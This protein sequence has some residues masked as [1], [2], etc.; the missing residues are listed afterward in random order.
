MA[1]SEIVKVTIDGVELALKVTGA[2]ATRIAAVLAACV[3]FGANQVFGNT[4]G[5]ENIKKL[6]KKGPITGFSIRYKDL[7]KFVR[8][9]ERYGVKYSA[10]T[11][12]D[13]MDGVDVPDPN[14]IVDIFFATD[15]AAQIERL[16]N[17]LDIGGID[18]VTIEAEDEVENP[19]LEN[20]G[21]EKTP[22]ETVAGLFG[23]KPEVANAPE[24]L[25]TGER[26]LQSELSSE[27]TVSEKS[28]SKENNASSRVETKITGEENYISFTEK[29]YPGNSLVQGKDYVFG[30]GTYDKDTGEI[31]KDINGQDL[32]ATLIFTPSQDVYE[33]GI[34][35][36]YKLDYELAGKSIGMLETVLYDG[37]I[38]EQLSD[39]NNAI[40]LPARGETVEVNQMEHEQDYK[41]V[42]NSG[43]GNEGVWEKAPEDAIAELFSSGPGANEGIETLITGGSESVN[44]VVPEQLK[45][46]IR[47]TLGLSRNL[48]QAQNNTVDKW[49]N[50]YGMPE[51]IIKEA[52]N[53]AASAEVERPFAYAN[54][55]IETWHNDGV[56]SLDDVKHSDEQHVLKSEKSGTYRYSNTNQFNNYEQRK[57]TLEE[58][59]VLEKKLIEAT[60][61]SIP[62]EEKDELW[63][64]FKAEQEAYKN[65]QQSTKPKTSQTSFVEEKPSVREKLN[66]IN[67]MRAEAEN[68][69]RERI[70]AEELAGVLSNKVNNYKEAVK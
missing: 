28:M 20:E 61:N 1:V 13:I 2:M 35:I 27:S 33:N 57:Y 59:Q 15:Q 11:D 38:I 67:A 26:S 16:L 53:R 21:K 55:I 51:D 25:W 45:N 65:E 48:S 40:L 32:K 9:A 58:E 18:R 63:K 23:S 14:S 7:E 17:H 6:L 31:L 42:E 41:V 29:F 44:T 5:Q 8:A 12:A 19:G 52:C 69:E 60:H 62:Q 22:E 43:T 70:L 36:S 50:E 64:K 47:D 46:D 34:D 68:V 49:V 4:N 3:K 54:K 37:I 66:N 56:Q 30:F 10:I 24:D 39:D